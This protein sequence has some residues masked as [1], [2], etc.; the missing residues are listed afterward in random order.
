MTIRT[1]FCMDIG[2]NNKYSHFTWHFLKNLFFENLLCHSLTAMSYG[3][4][5]NLHKNYV[6]KGDLFFLSD[7]PSILDKQE[8]LVA[9]LAFLFYLLTNN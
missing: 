5:F 4:R 3:H 1:F 9:S 6:Q 2:K 7:T 8:G